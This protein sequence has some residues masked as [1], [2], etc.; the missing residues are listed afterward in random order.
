M[1]AILIGL[2]IGI[3]LPMQTAVNSQLRDAV[4][5]PFGSSLVSF[6][7]GTVFLVIMTVATGATLLLPANFITTEPWW[8]WIGGVLGVFYLTAN[9]VLFP[10]LG[11]VQTVIMPIMGQILMSMLVDNYG[12]F[13]SPKHDLGWS[14]FVGAILVIIGVIL[15]VA[16]ES[17]VQ[18]RNHPLDAEAK[19]SVRGSGIWLW[20]IA[21]ILAGML[22]A[23]Q[24]AINGHLGTVLGSAV[25]ASLISFVVGTLLLIVIVGVG[26]RSFSFKSAVTGHW[27]WWIWSGGIIGAAFVVGNAYLVPK[28]GTGLAV[29]IV[30][31]G[32]IIG[33]MLID[34]FGW[35]RANRRPVVLIQIVGVLIMVAGV[36]M[37]KLV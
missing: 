6:A 18:N 24:T 30:L 8:I 25:K 14:R 29:V 19:K 10:R 17:W 34:Q 4:R 33:S 11:S 37:I 26:D 31:L 27:P 22:S 1:L 3:G 36:V 21:G 28:I 20:R 12:W 15:A 7:I 5:S 13:Y 32:Q 23:T 2:T 35:F 16:V 9:V